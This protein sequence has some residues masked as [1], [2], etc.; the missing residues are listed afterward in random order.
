MFDLVAKYRR[1]IMIGLFVLIIPPFALFGIDHYVRETGSAQTIAQVGDY[2]ITEHEFSEALRERQEMLRNMSGGKV[3]PA[4]LDSAEQRSDVLDALVRQRLLVNQGV[5]AGLGIT[6]EQLRGYI[7]QVPIF[8][9]ESKQ[10]SKERYQEF[11]RA[12]NTNAAAFENR[13]RHDLMISL[14]NDAYTDTNFVPRTVAERLARLT[15]QQREVSRALVSPEKFASTVKLE[16]GAAKKYYDEQQSEFRI[17]EQVRVEYVTLSA[18]AMMPLVK[19]DPADVKKFYDQN[20]RQFGTAETRE[21]SHILIAVD[22]GAPEA[23]KQ[24]ARALAESIAAEA[25]KNPERFAEL[26]KKH[27]QDPGSAAKGGEL[28]SFSRGAMVKPFDD[29]VFSMK[30]GEI[31]G[32]IETEYGYHVIRL[33][34]VTPG[35]MKTFEQ[36]RPEIERE[37]KK[38]GAARAYAEF[39]EK[40]NNLVFEQS[41]SLKPAAELLKQAPQKSGWITRAGAEDARLANPK[42]LQA[43]FSDDVLNGK[44]NTEAIEIAP[45]TIVAARIVEHKPATMRPFEEVK[46]AI[47]KKLVETRANQLAAQDGRQKLEALRQGKDAGVSWSAPVVV[48][49]ADPKG[50][51]EVIVRQA[52][53]ADPVNL[54]S[55]TG[56]EV[57]GG[58]YV[59]LRISKIVEPAKAD[60]AQQNQVAEGLA[61]LLGEAQFAAYVESL[62]QKTKVRVNKD[63]IQQK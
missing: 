6:T 33:T 20:Q 53:K 60:K 50:V 48:S 18:E 1:W 63:Q 2:G 55:Y 36:A 11:L 25:K 30:P 44:R 38:T 40:L 19:V 59:L 15:E 62:R 35:Q 24:K 29:A 39:A 56:V 58:G 27:S 13:L 46:A 3:D 47:E 17:A 34:G 54:P 12:R 14:L 21:A 57:P 41:D 61:Q 7:A 49:R 37:L 43:I 22:K 51:G 9:D 5:R 52:F 10:F 28:G 32:P 26:A 45:G 42:L 23:E 8:Q 4:M 16:E 31:S